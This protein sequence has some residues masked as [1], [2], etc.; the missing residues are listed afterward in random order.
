VFPALVVQALTGIH[1]VLTT[2][3]AAA[4]LYLTQL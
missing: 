2:L 3:V 1:T 4:A